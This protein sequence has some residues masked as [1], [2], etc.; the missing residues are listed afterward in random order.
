MGLA[1]CPLLHTLCWLSCLDLPCLVAT[2]RHLFAIPLPVIFGHSTPQPQSPPQLCL[3]PTRLQEPEVLTHPPNLFRALHCIAT[4][5]PASKHLAGLIDTCLVLYTMQDESNSG[6]ISDTSVSSSSSS[7]TSIVSS[8][9]STNTSATVAPDSA[10]TSTKSAAAA[11]AE[12]ASTA[13]VN[14][15]QPKKTR[16]QSPGAVQRRRIQNRIAQRNHRES[17]LCPVFLLSFQA[18]IACW[19]G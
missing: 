9:S 12:P 7:V 16:S 5:Q 18:R 1:P 19:E 11:G 2:Y 13:P 6:S 17:P 4:A 8:V 10:Q 14:P 3:Q 15:T